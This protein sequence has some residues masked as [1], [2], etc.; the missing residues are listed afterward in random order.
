MSIKFYCS[1]CEIG[2]EIRSIQ[3]LE[4]GY[5]VF[6]TPCAYCNDMAVKAIDFFRKYLQEQGHSAG[7]I[8][9]ELGL[10]K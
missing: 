6:I 9:K 8:A 4:S 5:G 10:K 7:E 2:V 3:Q 1:V